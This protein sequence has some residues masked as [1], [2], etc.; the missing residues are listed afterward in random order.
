MRI[1]A[2]GVFDLFHYGHV[3]LLKR[4]RELG[5]TLVVG[6][7]TDEDAQSYKRT[8]IMNLDERMEMVRSCRY[9]DEVVVA[10][11]V[12]TQEFIEAQR[13]DAVIHGSDSPQSEF[14]SVPIEL[15]IMRYLPYTDSVSTTD[16]IRRITHSGI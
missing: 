11:L 12:L 9:A 5:D 13:I 16:I 8:P 4:A 14:Y 1:Y 7:V 6:V 3:R 15:G 10:E 2:D